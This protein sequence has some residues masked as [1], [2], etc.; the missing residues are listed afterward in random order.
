MIP[1]GSRPSDSGNSFTSP[2]GVIR[3]IVL[4]ALATNQTLPSGPAVIAVGVPAPAG[5]A[6]EVIWPATSIRPIAPSSAN[7]TLP[8]GPVVIAPTRGCLLSGRGNSVTS[9]LVVTRPMAVMPRN[10]FS[11]ATQIAPSG[12]A[13]IAAARVE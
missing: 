2:P 1:P 10:S 11:A 13:V 6:N 5:S 9:P 7:Q 12:P 4:A 3:P 8:S